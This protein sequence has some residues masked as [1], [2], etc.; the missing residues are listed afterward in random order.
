MGDRIL[1]GAHFDSQNFAQCKH[2]RNA[3]A[4]RDQRRKG[5]DIAEIL[6]RYLDISALVSHSCYNILMVFMR[7]QKEHVYYALL[8]VAQT[9]LLFGPLAALAQT[10]GGLSGRLVTCDGPDCNYCSIAGLIQRLINF[11]VYLAVLAAGAMFAYAGYLYLFNNGEEGMIKKARAL[12]LQVLLGFMIILA[13][14]LLID[15]IMKTLLSG[16]FGPWNGIC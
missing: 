11:G 1:P 6:P 4:F 9:V 7:I 3:S 2:E 16:D 12:F 13:A 15:I 10:D 14:W 5:R 8:F